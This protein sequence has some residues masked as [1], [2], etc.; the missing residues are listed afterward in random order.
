MQLFGR[1]AGYI[2]GFPE[3]GTR[4]LTMKKRVIINRQARG[5]FPE[6]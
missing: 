4:E 5:N 2:A 1:Y 3:M 6:S